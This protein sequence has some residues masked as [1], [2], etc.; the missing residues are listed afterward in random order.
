MAFTEVSVRSLYVQAD[1]I[2]W[3]PLYPGVESKTLRITQ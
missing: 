1:G 3:Q 2:P